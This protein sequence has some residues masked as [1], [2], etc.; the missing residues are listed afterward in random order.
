[1]GMFFEAG[2]T[3][4]R[5]GLYQRYENPSGLALAGANNG[6]VA[7]V[8]QGSWGELGKVTTLN[9]E[10]EVLE[11]FGKDGTTQILN[12]AFAGGAKTIYAV[13]MGSGGTKGTGRLQDT[14]TPTAADAI[15]ITLKCEGNRVLEFTVRDMLGDATQ[16]EFLIMEGNV[17]LE[18]ITFPAS[19]S[20]EVDALM[21][22]AVGAKYFFMQKVASYSGTG[23]LAIT[24]K[25][26]FTAGTNPTV[27]NENYSTA[28]S[29]LEAF[30]WNTLIVDTEDTAVHSLA[31]TYMNR[32]YQQGKLGMLVVSEPHTVAWDDRLSH[33]KAFNNKN[34]VYLGTGWVDNLG[35][36][37]DG[38]LAAA[39]LGGMVSAIPSNQNL[40]HAVI[41]N[42]VTPLELLTNSQLENA[43]RNGMLALSVSSQG[44]VQIDAA[45][46]TLNN[47][48]DNEDEGWKKIK[49]CKIRNEMMTRISD[50]VEGLIGKLNNNADG[51]A[52]VQQTILSLLNVMVA[53]E[54][55]ASG[56]TVE[57]E[58]VTGQAGDSAYFRIKAY[59][60]DGL[61]KIYLTYEFSFNAA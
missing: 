52:F 36:E 49:R 27:N 12:E 14:G 21:E 32:M 34:V 44:A 57:I 50:T 31:A 17:V 10:A 29:A 45:V 16:K 37:Y 13:R 54:K 42:A 41:T 47:P 15:E 19:D 53:E 46:N 11:T 9:T 58:T 56:P 3:K 6:Y 38:Y 2:E 18:K 5:P 48:T 35:K 61:E 22:A 40:T 51:Q 59:D 4:L 60:I 33:A 24:A 8:V 55:L 20:G 25:T 7:A 39:R 28:F 23:K 43:I 1:M 26:A 30:N